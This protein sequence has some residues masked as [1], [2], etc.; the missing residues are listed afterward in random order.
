MTNIIFSVL[1][2]LG[3]GG[4]MFLRK[5]SVGKLGMNAYIFEALFGFLISLVFI[6]LF[7]PFDLRETLKNNGLFYAIFG[8][9]L[10]GLGII[11]FFKASQLGS[12]MV[13]S[14]IAPILGAIVVVFLA[15]VFLKDS[16]TLV[17]IGGLFITII[18]LYLFVK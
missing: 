17:K 16:L 2:G 3:F 18:G 14:L 12:V 4:A 8:G 15:V 10:M 11:S 5:L 6:P 13:P 9:I 1:A 7:F